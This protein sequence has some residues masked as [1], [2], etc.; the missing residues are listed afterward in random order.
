MWYRTIL[1][2]LMVQLVHHDF[3]NKWKKRNEK[4]VPTHIDFQL[5]YVQLRVRQRLLR[6]LIVHDP[7]F[8]MVPITPLSLSLQVTISVT[9][10]KIRFFRQSL[11]YY[12]FPTQNTSFLLEN[13]RRMAT[14]TDS[15]CRIQIKKPSSL[16]FRILSS[17]GIFP[18]FWVGLNYRNKSIVIVQ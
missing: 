8:H 4:W 18:P 5:T 9:K 14:I 1:Q 13:S 17:S 15:V 10:S 16:L 12:F 2:N 6:F 3:R 7:A 11:C